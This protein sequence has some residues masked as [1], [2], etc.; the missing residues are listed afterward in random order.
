MRYAGS[1]MICMRK[2]AASDLKEF[3]ML[4]RLHP[5]LLHTSQQEA[6]RIRFKDSRTNHFTYRCSRWLSPNPR[7]N[8]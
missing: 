8:S 4:T 1:S 3:G 7:H 5:S 6:L 2:M